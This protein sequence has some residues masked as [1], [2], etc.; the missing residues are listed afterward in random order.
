MRSGQS[1]SARRGGFRDTQP[2]LGASTKPRGPGAGW[3]RRRRGCGRGRRRGCGRG[4]VR[5]LS[6][7]HLGSFRE[8]ADG[9]SATA[10]RRGDRCLYRPDA[11]GHPHR[12]TQ[13][14]DRRP[15]RPRQ[16][17]ARR[18]ACSGSPGA[19]RDQARTS[20]TACMD[21]MDLEREKGITILAKNTALRYGGREAQHH[22]HA[23]ATP[24]S[25]A[26]SSAG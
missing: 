1:I 3:R 15:R 11:H 14:R 18:R 13:R 17:H 4:T 23:R 7:P 10:S 12:H 20:P 26:R 16:D 22:R 8:A 21:S 9:S 2:E 5:P 25:A 24:T 19:F 6:R